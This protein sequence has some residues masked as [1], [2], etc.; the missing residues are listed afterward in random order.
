ML[1]E[2]NNSIKAKLYDFQYTPFMSSVVIS[3][4]IINH[5]YILIYF[6]D[7]KIKT[8]LD[9]LNAYS[10]NYEIGQFNI[11]YYFNFWIPILFG[12]FYVFIYP[13]ISKM[14][15]K[16]TLN[17]TKELKA[18]KQEIHDETPIT[19]LEAKNLYKNI[20]RLTNERDEV[21]VKYSKLEGEYKERFKKEAISE[22]P[23]T[24]VSSTVNQLKDVLDDTNKKDTMSDKD[25]VLKFFYESNFK[26]SSED[27]TLDSIVK[28]TNIRRPKI[29]IILNELISEKV[30]SKD[31]YK[32]IDITDKGNIE[33]IQ[34][35]D[36][37]K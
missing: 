23:I 9:L 19:Q 18:I 27:N 37:G 15:Y 29:K 12:L 24:D 21:I 4:I 7:E 36:G 11:P 26:K 30:L 2:L 32:N 13:K 3:W 5:K 14:F 25:K 10:F 33:L 17:R 31:T 22:I 35:F 34:L 16:Y 1:T 8:K 6:S 20:E 28:S